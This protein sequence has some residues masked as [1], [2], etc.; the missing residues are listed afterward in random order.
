MEPNN[1]SGEVFLERDKWGHWSIGP[2]S[3]YH[4]LSP[5]IEKFPEVE[6]YLSWHP[7]EQLVRIS[8][9][10]SIGHRAACLA[11]VAPLLWCARLKTLNSTVN[12]VPLYIVKNKA[13]YLVDPLH[14]TRK[15]S[16]QTVDKWDKISNDVYVDQ[17]VLTPSWGRGYDSD[18]YEVFKR[19]KGRYFKEWKRHLIKLSNASLLAIIDIQERWLMSGREIMARVIYEIVSSRLVG[20]GGGISPQAIN[21]SPYL[22]ERLYYLTTLRTVFTDQC[23]LLLRSKVQILSFIVSLLTSTG[24]DEESFCYLFH[25]LRL[26]PFWSVWKQEAS[27]TLSL[28]EEKI[29][30]KD[31]QKKLHAL[32]FGARVRWGLSLVPDILDKPIEDPSDLCSL[33]LTAEYK[34]L[35]AFRE[36]AL[37]VLDPFIVYYGEDCQL[38]LRGEDYLKDRQKRCWNSF[39]KAV[40]VASKDGVCPDPYLS[41]LKTKRYQPPRRHE[42][43]YQ[44]NNRWISVK[45]LT[46]RDLVE[47]K[48]W[49]TYQQSWSVL[50]HHRVVPLEVALYQHLVH[51]E[52]LDPYLSHSEEWYNEDYRLLEKFMNEH[53]VDHWLTQWVTQGHLAAVG[54]LFKKHLSSEKFRFKDENALFT[55]WTHVP[56]NY[57]RELCSLLVQQWSWMLSDKNLSHNLFYKHVDTFMKYLWPLCMKLFT[58]DQLDTCQRV[59]LQTFKNNG[60]DDM[61][62][63]LIPVLFVRSVGEPQSWWKEIRKTLYCKDMA[64]SLIHSILKKLWYDEEKPCDTNDKVLR[65][66][67]E[68]LFIHLIEQR[69]LKVMGN[70]DVEDLLATCLSK[71]TSS[72]EKA[73]KWLKELN[74]DM[75]AVQIHKIARWWPAYKWDIYKHKRLLFHLFQHPEQ[76]YVRTEI[77]REANKRVGVFIQTPQMKW[78]TPVGK[79]KNNVIHLER[80]GIS[81][82]TCPG[83]P[84]SVTIHVDDGTTAEYTVKVPPYGKRM[85]VNFDDLVKITVYAGPELVVWLKPWLEESVP[86]KRKRKS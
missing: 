75:H 50:M 19:D 26:F 85:E 17:Y 33:L 14:P 5:I 56:Q 82:V 55:V 35:A 2:Y 57:Q 9:G 51:S 71:I 76:S 32:H 20:E 23:Q 78:E 31:V 27:A 80:E 48:T 29:N 63:V 7:P 44:Y 28:H 41:R 30:E 83:D 65:E 4:S 45:I 60:K 10:P 77:N 21:V 25:N 42:L 22:E 64:L 52:S 18:L 43:E 34:G 66:D 69:C 58:S 73:F 61:L 46:W 68:K 40:L 12:E 3:F 47:D 79:S 24:V 49:G 67:Y 59:V 6:G 74:P 36:E 37:T 62:E 86:K 13:G 11:L 16:E 1:S 70:S 53:D 39:L 15:L 38:R 8:L 84:L 72:E 81:W 54:T